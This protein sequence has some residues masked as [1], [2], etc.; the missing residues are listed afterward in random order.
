MPVA[1]ADR[2]ALSG[3]AQFPEESE[4]VTVEEPDLLEVGNGKVITGSLQQPG[5]IPEVG[6]RRHPRRHA[7]G[8]G[9]LRLRAAAAPFREGAESGNPGQPQSFRPRSL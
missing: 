1:Q 2:V 5:A 9:G 8:Q 7:T 6:A 3:R 4:R